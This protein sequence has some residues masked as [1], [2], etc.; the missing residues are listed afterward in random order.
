MVPDRVAAEDPV[1]DLMAT[2]MDIPLSTVKNT[3][4]KK[5]FKISSSGLKKH[6]INFKDW[7]NKI[8]IKAG[9]L[10][11]PIKKIKKI[12]K[13]LISDITVESKNHSFIA[14]ESNFTSS[15]S[16]MG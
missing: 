11:V 10:F 3:L 2:E 4:T 5:N 13:T 16:A 9:S 12:E 6:L 1:P 14:G 8:K 15:N 7:A